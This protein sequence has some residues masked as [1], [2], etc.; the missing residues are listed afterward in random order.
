MKLKSNT[1]HPLGT[2]EVESG[3]LHVT[4]PDQSAGSP[5]IATIPA[6]N[7]TWIAGITTRQAGAFG[8]RIARLEIAHCDAE[9]AG[10][11]EAVPVEV[12]VDSGQAGFFDAAHYARNDEVSEF[13]TQH[14]RDR[15]L[16]H[17][18]RL[19]TRPDYQRD[20]EVIE[21]AAIDPEL[22]KRPVSELVSVYSPAW[23]AVSCMARL[24][25]H[26]YLKCMACTD[27]EDG[28]GVLPFGVVSQ[29][30]LGD[31]AYDLFIQRDAEGDAVRAQLVFIGSRA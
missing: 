22:G 15:L 17:I 19:K 6:R 5:K 9:P 1:M 14:Q 26:W 13:E 4:D 8:G 27:S 7:G 2:F 31:G 23:M 28:A 3:R 18:E 25:Q 21:R 24:N 11:W 29:S 12:E 16:E 10:A 30:G 20:M